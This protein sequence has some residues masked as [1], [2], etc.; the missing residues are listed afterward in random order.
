[1]DY[2][3]M[4]ITPLDRWV[5]S[6]LPIREPLSIAQLQDYQLDRLRK[7]LEYVLSRSHFYKEHLSGIDPQSIRS[8]ED[9]ARIP[10]T[11]SGAL[12]ARFNDFLCVSPRDISRIV[13]LSTSG[14]TGRAKRIAFTP[15]D[16]ETTVDFF[17]HGM[18]TLVKTLDRVVIFM[19]G[20]TE[21]SVGDLLQ[22][23]LSRFGCEGI[24]FGPIVDYGRALK[25]LIDLK[26]ACVVGIPSQL[27]ALSRY[28]ES[29]FAPE[30]IHLNRVLLSTDYVPQAIAYSLA[31]TWGCEVYGHY[32]M[33]EMGLGGAVECSA[34]NGYHMREAD[35]LFEIIDPI[36]GR[37]VKSGE[38]GE[39]VF[40]TLT[41]Q[42]MPLIRYKTGDRSRFIAAPCPCGSALKR[43][44]R[45]SGRIGEA[46][47]LSDGSS[48]SISQLDEVLFR[49]S[50]VSAY[51][52]EM[53]IKDNCDCLTL[54]VQSAQAAI[55]VHQIELELCRRYSIG[56]LVKQG[57]LKLDIHE[58]DAGYFT[59]GTSKR[60]IADRRN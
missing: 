44:A 12:A 39:V 43:M 28:G 57:R 23:A 55:D 20:E 42:G 26:P 22:K 45:I 29:G 40:S 48:I 32:G 31:Q 59:T 50:R 33:T 3:L 10:F 27:L 38:Y 18:M 34:R 56:T 1:V 8:M 37:P 21:G 4:E 51:A 47:P 36:A 46:V 5:A 49:D 9:V 15:E 25:T 24:A 35:L 11:E 19:P 6:K 7:T 53:K 30:Q 52:A 54:T 14:T 16:Q 13:T 17:H 60:F 2:L 58:G 41:R